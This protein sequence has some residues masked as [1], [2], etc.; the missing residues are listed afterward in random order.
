MINFNKAF[1]IKLGEGGKWEDNSIKTGKIRIGWKNIPLNL[2][3]NNSWEDIRQLVDEDFNSRGKKNGATNDFNAL[4]NICHSDENTVFITFSNGKMYW[5]LAKSSSIAEDGISKYILTSI[6]WSDHDIDNT[7]IFYINQ[8]SGRIT[9]YQLYKGTCCKIGSEIGEFDYLTQII[10]NQVNEDF[11]KIGESI[12]TLRN[13]LIKPI[14][15]LIPKDFEILIDLIFRNNGWRRTSVLGEVMKFFDIIL[16]EPFTNKLFGVQIKSSCSNI[17][18]KNYADKFDTNYA[19]DFETL[20]F[21]VHTPKYL[22][23]LIELSKQYEN[24]RLLTINEIADLVINAGL[25]KWITDKI[26]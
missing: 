9:K 18:F 17:E 25:V 24:I 4:K 6:P 23:N 14:Q 10:N 8:I 21:I 11:V 16:E 20:Y 3:Q 15:S 12:E 1:Y 26:K 19:T 13:S 5:S 2:I 22:E 7:K